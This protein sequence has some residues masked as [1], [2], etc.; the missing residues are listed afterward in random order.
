ML[1]LKNGSHAG[2]RG[3]RVAFYDGSGHP[4]ASSN[5]IV[6]AP[7][8]SLSQPVSS[9]IVNGSW[10][11]GSIEIFY[12]GRGRGR[13]FGQAATTDDTTSISSIVEIQHAG[14]RYLSPADQAKK[15]D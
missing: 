8:G 6:L 5:R 9:F 15:N 2:Q 4:V 12:A 7:R 13:M 1:D 11:A 10:T 3:F 14:A